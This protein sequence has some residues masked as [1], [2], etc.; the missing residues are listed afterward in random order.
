MD[1]ATLVTED[2][3]IG[4][5][6]IGLL[7]AAG[8]PVDDAFWVYAPQIDEWR[9]VLSSRKVKDLGVRNC[10]LAMSNALHE[11]PLLKQIPL[12][13]ISLL[14][15]DD[16]VVQRMRRLERHIY[17]GALHVVRSH[18][19]NR[20]PTF[21]VTFAPYRDPG[22]AIPTV[23]FGG[24]SDLEKFLR[25]QIKIEDYDIRTAARELAV[26]GSYSFPNVQ[27]ATGQLRRL[28]LL[29]PLLGTSRK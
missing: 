5:D 20:P 19:P 23:A 22:G 29:P 28:R 24:E 13:R 16:E 4:N 25:E 15:P 11:S 12:R 18:R 10:Y 9:L 14:S 2:L 7:T 21:H 3:R 8:I 6:V 17:E 1:K 27:L 26:R